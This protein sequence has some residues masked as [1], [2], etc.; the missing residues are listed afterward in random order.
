LTQQAASVAVVGVGNPDRGD[1]GAGPDVARRVERAVGGVAGVTIVAGTDPLD[2]L[3]AVAGAAEVHVVDACRSGAPP[4]TVRRWD[5]IGGPAGR[6]A[7]A[8][9]RSSHGVGIADA[10]ELAR[11]LGRLPPTVVV[12][13]IEVQSCDLGAGLSPA[14]EAA[15][16]VVAAELAA[17]VRAGSAAAGRA[18]TQ[19][20]PPVR[21]TVRDRPRRCGR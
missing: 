2:L 17:A 21:I 10:L 16:E 14:V 1:D 4:G 19:P 3:D 6:A 13:T 8:G 11:V 15:V 20:P 9:R 7:G 12:H 18:T 5:A